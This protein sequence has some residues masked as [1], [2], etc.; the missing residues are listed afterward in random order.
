MIKADDK[1]KYEGIDEE[2]QPKFTNFELLQQEVEVLKENMDEIVEILKYN[3]I[4][5]KK[6]IKPEYFDIDEVFKRLE[7]SE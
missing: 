6:T 3:D 2:N 4:D 5:R 1:V 7:D